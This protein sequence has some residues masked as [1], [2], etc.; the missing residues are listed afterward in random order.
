MKIQALRYYEIKMAELLF[1]DFGYDYVKP[2]WITYSKAWFSP[3]LANIVIPGA[4]TISSISYEQALKDNKRPGEDG[5]GVIV[6]GAIPPKFTFTSLISDGTQENLLYDALPIWQKLSNPENKIAIPVYHFLLPK[7]GV[8]T[9]LIQKVT[10]APPKDGG[11]MELN[12]DCIAVTEGKELISKAIKKG[13]GPVAG[14]IN[15]S[16]AVVVL[17]NSPSNKVK[18]K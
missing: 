1:S 5:G 4:V 8:S 3:T 6:Q 18:V 12:I 17:K 7:F 15:K 9:C 14:K 16:K 2:S 11:A 13:V 10:L